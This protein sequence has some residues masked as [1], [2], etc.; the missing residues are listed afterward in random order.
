M[1]SVALTA[2]IVTQAIRIGSCGSRVLREKLIA[3]QNDIAR[4]FCAQATR[5]SS[6]NKRELYLRV[7]LEVLKIAL[8]DASTLV[9]YTEARDDASRKSKQDTQSN[10]D[11][12]INEV[13]EG[14][15]TTTSRS[16]GFRNWDRNR[17]GDDE[18]NSL[19]RS[20]NRANSYSFFKDASVSKS[21]SGEEGISENDQRSEMS[22]LGQ[23]TTDGARNS[24]KVAY[25]RPSGEGGELGYGK[26]HKDEPVVPSISA[27]L[28][29]C[30]AV[31]WWIPSVTNS[32]GNIGNFINCLSSAIEFAN[33]LQ[34]YSN[35]EGKK[36][37]GFVTTG[38]HG[39]ASANPAPTCSISLSDDLCDDSNGHGGY[40]WQ[41]K[42]ST[43]PS[44]FSNYHAG[45]FSFEFSAGITALGTGVGFTARFQLQ[46]GET[47]SQQARIDQS[48]DFSSSHS[49]YCSDGGTL[50]AQKSRSEN[51]AA[52]ASQTKNDKRR[53][54]E[55]ASESGSTLAATS[56]GT[57]RF[58]GKSGNG[59]DRTFIRTGNTTV[60]KIGAIE[61]LAQVRLVDTSRMRMESITH[62]RHQVVKMIE[63][64]IKTTQQEIE[65]I[66]EAKGRKIAPK[67]SSPDLQI[68]CNSPM[69]KI[70]TL[71]VRPTL[72]GTYPLFPASRIINS[73]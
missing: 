36:D 8:L 61:E 35:I 54:S 12:S 42:A 34:N 65:N 18:S 51:L 14:N 71:Y 5:A 25:I 64:L 68:R 23:G 43:L 1:P 4:L 17:T 46:A 48:Y 67:A 13:R 69:G 63:D 24:S 56:V 66:Q 3:K 16:C 2:T 21:A 10:R 73:E 47:F 19:A 32:G 6:F 9:D 53:R 57:M 11:G 22:Q 27:E 44:T 45:T 29:G 58:S 40:I 7:L 72:R 15:T 39:I 52:S 50:S 30:G 38:I 20:K 49:F 26:D 55:K 62:Y 28:P 37:S 59:N 70:G 33:G 60:N 41:R 31:D